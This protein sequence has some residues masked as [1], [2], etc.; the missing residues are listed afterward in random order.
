MK[1]SSAVDR[2]SEDQGF[3]RPQLAAALGIEPDEESSSAPLTKVVTISREEHDRLQR[4]IRRGQEAVAEGA[5][6]LER[7]W[8]DMSVIA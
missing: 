7:R 4:D 6:D 2:E 3:D 5:D 8:L 1:T